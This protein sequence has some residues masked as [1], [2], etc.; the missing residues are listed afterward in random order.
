MKIEIPDEKVEA[1]VKELLLNLPEC[2]QDT[3][4]CIGWKY[5]LNLYKFEDTETGK[6]YEMTLP[7]AIKGFERLVTE[8]ILPGKIHLGISAENLFDG[9]GWDAIAIDTLC[10]MAILGEVRY[11]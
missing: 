8:E 9:G 3:L 6:K 11:G 5:S 1:F 4:R 2:A 10:Q 7:M